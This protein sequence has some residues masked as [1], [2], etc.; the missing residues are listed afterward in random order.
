M[1]INS[2]EKLNSYQNEK[3]LNKPPS[4]NNNSY[5]AVLYGRGF[6]GETT[7]NYASEDDDFQTAQSLVQLGADVNAKDIFGNTSL[8]NAAANGNLKIV[9]LLVENG[10]I[11]DVKNIWG[12]TSIDNAKK[13]KEVMIILNRLILFKNNNRLLMKN[14]KLL[15]AKNFIFPLRRYLTKKRLLFDKIIFLND[16]YSYQIFLTAP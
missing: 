16:I 11:I 8:H 3:I 12:K 14:L 4:F 7:L 10:A 13:Y 5:D 1:I 2:F 9:K 6:L 15:L